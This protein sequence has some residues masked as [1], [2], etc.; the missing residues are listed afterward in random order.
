MDPTAVYKSTA[1]T[2]KPQVAESPGPAMASDQVV[3]GDMP[4]QRA[5]LQPRRDLL[6][7]LNR[8]S[9]GVSVAVLT[10][11]PGVGKTQLAATYARAR[12]VS[13]WRLIAWVDAHDGQS[14]LAGLTAVVEATALPA[15]RPLHGADRPL[16]GTADA[17]QAVRRWLEDDGSRCLL[18]FDGAEDPA[19]LRPFIPSAGA[20]RVV[21]TAS[22]EPGEKLGTTVPVNAFGGEEAVAFLNERTGLGDEA[23][24]EAVAAALGQLPLALDQAAATIAGQHL[25]YATYLAKLRALAATGDLIAQADA[26]QRL[27]P[28]GVAEAVLLSLDAVRV[29]DP[30]GVCTAIM[31]MMAMLG[32]APVRCELLGAAGQAGALLGGGRRVAASMVDQALGQLSERSLLGFSHD[33]QD[34]SVH[35]LAARVVRGELARRGRLATAFRAA[36]SALEIATGAV[37]PPAVGRPMSGQVTE[38]LKTAGEHPEAVDEQVARRLMRLGLA[39]L[40]QLVERRDSMPLVITIGEPLAADLERLLGPGHPDTLNACNSLAVAYRTLGRSADAIPLVRKI[41]IGRERLL[42]ADHPSTLAARNNLAIAYRTAGRPAEAIP[43]F[44]ENMAA[45]ERVLGADHPR[46]LASRHNLDLARQESA[47]G[48]SAGETGG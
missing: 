4:D 11:R 17:G 42:G 29:A 18:V 36:A 1:G 22:G 30:L 3:V 25:D 15:D 27:Y 6:A 39:V 23:G 9:Q 20:A 35:W 33:G 41:L 40:S 13:G 47:Q 43:L 31:E 7:K 8:T 46:T 45:C 19:Q 34:V 12:L 26:E 14:L 2:S 28:P 21:I 32:A 48:E 24:A 5:G 10:G 16:H 38:L 37:A 44:E